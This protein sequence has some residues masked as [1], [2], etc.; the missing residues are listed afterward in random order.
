VERRERSRAPRPAAAGPPATNFKYAR[1]HSIGSLADRQLAHKG[2]FGSDQQLKAPLQGPR[3]LRDARRLQRRPGRR[4][5]QR[6]DARL[7]PQGAVDR[8]GLEERRRRRRRFGGGSGGS[9]KPKNGAAGG[10]PP[11]IDN[12]A[13]YGGGDTSAPDPAQAFANAQGKAPV[14]GRVGTGPVKGVDMRV[15]D[16]RQA[17]LDNP[18]AAG[19]THED[20]IRANI[21]RAR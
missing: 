2:R 16:G 21:A 20:Y 12:K 18:P 17:I 13:I 4:S 6:R 5:Q 19:P 1:D 15:Q 10:P 9:S 7:H 3:R 8:E 11:K 14:K